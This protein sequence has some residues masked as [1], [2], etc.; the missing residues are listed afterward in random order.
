MGRAATAARSLS[1]AAAAR[2]PISSGASQSRRKCTPST[3]MSVESAMPSPATTAQS[4]PGPTR[5]SAAL[6]R[7]RPRQKAADQVELVAGR[8]ADRRVVVRAGMD[9]RIGAHD[10]MNIVRKCESARV[11]GNGSGVKG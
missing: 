4:S 1:A 2:Q 9:G 10:G 6:G 11:R 5:T 8:Q 7:R 3:L